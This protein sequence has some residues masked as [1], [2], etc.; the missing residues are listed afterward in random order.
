M[1]FTP[2]NAKKD[3]NGRLNAVLFLLVISLFMGS[4]LL[5]AVNIAITILLSADVIKN[6]LKNN[7]LL[8]QR[9]PSANK[10]LGANQENLYINNKLSIAL[11]FLIAFLLTITFSSYRNSGEVEL[12][13][14]IGYLLFI[15]IPTLFSFLKGSIAISSMLN[16]DM[17]FVVFSTV[18]AIL[19]L[20]SSLIS[21]PGST[22]ILPLH[23]SIQNLLLYTSPLLAMTLFKRDHSRSVRFI[24]WTIVGSAILL[25]DHTYHVFIYAIVLIVNCMLYRDGA[26]RILSIFF[27][28]TF[29]IVSVYLDLS[30]AS[31]MPYITSSVLPEKHLLT[32]TGF[33]ELS[34]GMTRD[35]SSNQYF[36]TLVESGILGLLFLLSAIVF[37]ISNIRTEILNKNIRTMLQLTLAIILLNSF[38][39]PTFSHAE[40]RQFCMVLL[41]WIMSK[42]T[43]TAEKSHGDQAIVC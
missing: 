1:E 41:V 37:L 30:S 28:V 2:I 31:E 34:V 43:Q 36:I 40:S 9:S 22:S 13:V 23:T 42:T 15:M 4:S 27:T 25:S 8:S 7:S 38:Y 11:L 35:G 24:L 20:A 21:L 12:S 29:G 3:Q 5:L 6:T 32:G 39:H 19:N 16:K 18:C 14:F 10:E 26:I 17:V 33:M